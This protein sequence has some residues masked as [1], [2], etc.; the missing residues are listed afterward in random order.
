MTHLPASRCLFTTHPTCY[1]PRDGALVH[2]LDHDGPVRHDRPRGESRAVD[3]ALL[4]DGD[5]VA[6]VRAIDDRVVAQCELVADLGYRR[7]NAAGGGLIDAPVDHAVGADL[8]VL[9]DR[10]AGAVQRVERGLT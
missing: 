9:A 1:S 7:I 8:G 2:A 4:A 6:D 10:D 3:V 5:I